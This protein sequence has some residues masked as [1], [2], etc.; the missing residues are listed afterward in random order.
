MKKV[1]LA[2]VVAGFVAFTAVQT[3]AMSVDGM[4]TIF[5]EKTKI[6]PE[7]LPDAIKEAI[8]ND[9]AVSSS[10]ITEAHQVMKDNQIYYEVKFDKDAEG[11]AA[12]KK[13]DSTGKE[14]EGAD[15][16]PGS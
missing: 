16:E 7:N 9:A 1:M 2:L 5:Q 6:D 15:E 4:E 3:Q 14:V 8:Q 10:Q 11:N 13:Y 12:T